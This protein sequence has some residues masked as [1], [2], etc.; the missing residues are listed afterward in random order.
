MLG[1]ITGKQFPTTTK[2][3]CQHTQKQNI[4]GK[5]NL[6]QIEKRR[7]QKWSQ[8]KT[9]YPNQFPLSEGSINL[10]ELEK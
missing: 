5:P 7:K 9:G 3:Y 2:Q 10:T 1:Y 8:R 6:S 4:P